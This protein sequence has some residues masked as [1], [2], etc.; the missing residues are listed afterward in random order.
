MI[1]TKL[2]KNNN[3]PIEKVLFRPIISASYIWIGMD[4]KINAKAI[5][6]PTQRLI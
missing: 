5:V 1:E 3:L 2:L 4:L 6:P